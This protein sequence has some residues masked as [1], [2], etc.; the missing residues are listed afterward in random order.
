M[1]R[2][3]IITLPNPHL[4][5]RSQKVGIITEEIKKLIADM[6]A[7]TLDWEDNRSLVA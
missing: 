6:K 2:H 4:R 7:A 3:S 5:Q 1:D